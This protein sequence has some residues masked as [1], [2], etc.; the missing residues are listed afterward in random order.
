VRAMLG[1]SIT[2]IIFTVLVVFLVWRLFSW[3]RQNRLKHSNRQNDLGGSD[4]G[5]TLEPQ[6]T[7]QCA[8]C[9]AYVPVGTGNC[10]REDCPYPL[11]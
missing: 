2:K 11:S 7:A 10:G 8:V 1:L 4:H 6:D 3:I 9:Q 5:A